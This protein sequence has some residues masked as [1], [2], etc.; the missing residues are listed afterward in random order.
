MGSAMRAA[1]QLPEIGPLMWLMHLHVNQYSDYDDENYP[2]NQLILDC[3][4]P[5]TTSLSNILIWVI[6]S[7][8]VAVSKKKFFYYLYWEKYPET[9]NKLS[10]WLLF[11]FIFSDLVLMLLK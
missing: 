9:K 5:I 3:F 6:E 10:K 1:S 8:I 11:N 7:Y 2:K 4:M